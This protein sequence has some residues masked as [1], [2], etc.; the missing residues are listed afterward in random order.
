MTA[1]FGWLKKKKK[2][3]QK[4]KK[5]MKISLSYHFFKKMIA[6][7]LA[8]TMSDRKTIMI[9]WYCEVL[10]NISKYS[11]FWVTTFRDFTLDHV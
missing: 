7:N 10:K 11:L 1:D 5:A 2:L 3:N 9:N 6:V 8:E 4:K